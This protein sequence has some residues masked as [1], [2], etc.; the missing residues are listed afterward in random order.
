MINQYRKKNQKY[1][2]WCYVRHIN[3][4]KKHPGKIKK[5]IKNFLQKL[6]YGVIEFPVRDKGFNK[7]QVKNNICINVFWL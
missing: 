2:F 5:M 1:F 3:L 6:D 7:I 4:S